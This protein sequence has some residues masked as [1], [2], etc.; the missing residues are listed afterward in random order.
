MPA[1][2]NLDPTRNYLLEQDNY[3]V[4]TWRKSLGSFAEETKALGA[5]LVALG[6]HGVGATEAR[7]KALT[8]AAQHS[9]AAQSGWMKPEVGRIE[10]I[11]LT[12][13][14]GVGR[15]GSYA[16]YQLPKG[17]ALLAGIAGTGGVTGGIAKLGVRKGIKELAKAELRTVAGELAAKKS[18]QAFVANAAKGMLTTPAERLAGQAARQQVGQAMLRGAQVGAG[19]ATLGLETGNLYGD[20]ANDPNVGPEKAVLPSLAGG[21]ASAALEYLPFHLAGKAV[22][23]D[24]LLKGGMLRETIKSTP[25]LSKK[26]RALATRVAKGAASGAVVEG[27]TEGLQ[28]LVQLA[29]EKYAKDDPTWSNV[30]PQNEDEWSRVWNA[31]A[32]GGLVG[33]VAGAGIGGVGKVGQEEVAQPPGEVVPTEAP[34][35]PQPQQQT[36]PQ[37]P[38]PQQP[39]VL[40]Q[41]AVPLQ[42]PVAQTPAPSPLPPAFQFDPNAGLT[43]PAPEGGYQAK[44]LKDYAP[45]LGAG[46]EAGATQVGDTLPVQETPQI[47]WQG[48]DGS[49]ITQSTSPDGKPFWSFNDGSGVEEFSSSESPEVYAYASEKT[50]V[51][52]PEVPN[53]QQEPG[54]SPVYGDVQQ[55]PGPQVGQEE[56][57]PVPAAEGG[58]GIQQE[59]LTSPAEPTTI[60]SIEDGP[61]VGLTPEE[62]STLD[63]LGW[64]KSINIYGAPTFF[65]SQNATIFVQKVGNPKDGYTW[66]ANNAE[67]TLGYY[68]SLQGAI[69]HVQASKKQVVPQPAL[70]ELKQIWQGPGEFSKKAHK[71]ASK[72]PQGAKF[73][74]EAPPPAWE[75]GQPTTKAFFV[76]ESLGYGTVP[77]VFW[78]EYDTVEEAKEAIPGLIDLTEG[79]PTQESPASSKFDAEAEAVAAAY[80]NE[81]DPLTALQME[82]EFNNKY[83][84][85]AFNNWASTNTVAKE[86]EQLPPL[87]HKLTKVG[88]QAGSNNGG[89]YEDELGA[90]YYVKENKTIDQTVS[91]Y[92]ASLLYAA[93]GVPK[94]FTK[95]LDAPE[96][97]LSPIVIASLKASADVGSPMK[98]GFL[99]DAWLANWDVAGESND[100]FLGTK[101]KGIRVDFGGTLRYRAKGK[102]KG[103]SGTKEF[104]DRVRELYTL[105]DPNVNPQAAALF[106]DLT[107]A[108]IIEQAASLGLLKDEDIRK[109]VTTPYSGIVVENAQELADTL[110][111]R[112]QRILNYAAK[113]VGKESVP[114]KHA[115]D[116]WVANWNPNSPKGLEDALK[117]VDPHLDVWA[118]IPKISSQY[119]VLVI[120]PAA[121]KVLLRKPKNNYDGY[122]WTFSKG[123]AEYAEHPVDTAKRETFEE[124][125]Q[126]THIVGLIGKPFYSSTSTGALY[127]V[128][129][130]DGP[131]IGTGAETEATKWVTY[132]E[133]KKLIKEGTNLQE[134]ERDL[135][136]LDYLFGQKKV[137]NVAEY[138]IKQGAFHAKAYFEAGKFAQDLASSEKA[139]ALS[140]KE[141]SQLTDLQ[142]LW[143]KS[144]AQ[145]AYQA[146]DTG[147]IT[148]AEVNAE[149]S[150]MRKNFK[151]WSGGFTF[152][153][154]TS[155]SADTGTTKPIAE[156]AF[157]TGQPMVATVFHGTGGAGIVGDRVTP[158]KTHGTYGVGGSDTTAAGPT[159]W[160]YGRKEHAQGAGSKVYALY[161]KMSNPLVVDHGGHFWTPLTKHIQKAKNN[162]HDGLIV[163]NIEDTS[164]DD[165]QLGTQFVV[166]HGRQ[167]K[168]RYLENFGYSSEPG[169]KIYES[170][171]SG[172]AAPAQSAIDFAAET[173]GLFGQGFTQRAIDSGVLIVNETSPKGAPSGTFNKRTG[174][175][176]INLDRVPQYQTATSVLLHEGR[177]AK[178]GEILG[179]SITEFHNDLQKLAKNGSATARS[180][181]LESTR[182][183]AKSLGIENE[184]GNSA[185]PPAERAGELTRVREEIQRRRPDL[186]LEEDLAYYVQIA[187]SSKTVVEAGFLR[188]LIEAIKTWW[189][190]TG[191]GQALAQ[192]G[193]R[194]EFTP[195]MA[196]ELAKASTRRAVVEAEQMQQARARWTDLLKQMPA[197][198]RQAILESRTDEM[199]VKHE[200]VWSLPITPQL[201]EEALAGQVLYSI[202]PVSSWGDP[203]TWFTSP[204]SGIAENVNEPGLGNKIFHGLVDRFEYVRGRS[205][206]LYRAFDEWKNRQGAMQQEVERQFLDPMVEFVGRYEPSTGD[207]D[208]VRKAKVA[209]GA[210]ENVKISK[211]EMV[212]HQLAARHILEDDVTHKLARRA[213]PE[214]LQQL[215][216]ELPPTYAGTLNDQIALLT[217]GSQSIKELD[218]DDAMGLVEQYLPQASKD[219][220]TRWALMNRRSAGYSIATPGSADATVDLNDGFIN[221]HEIYNQQVKD[222]R[223]FQRIGALSDALAEH[224]LRI[225]QEG[226]LLTESSM[227]SLRNSY[228]HYV[229]LRREKFDYDKEL[230]FLFEKPSKRIGQMI[231][232]EGSETVPSAVHVLQ[233][234][235]AGGFTTA[236]AAARNQMMNKFA[237][238]IYEDKKG[239]GPWFRISEKRENNGAMGFVRNGK[240]LF[241]IPN[242]ENIRAASISAVI[243]GYDAQK[244]AGPMKL[245]RSVNNWIRWSNV[246]ASPI[247]LLSNTPRDY[248]TAVYN[249]QASEAGEYAKE[250]S[251]WKNYKKSFL[252]LKKVILE[253]VRESTDP[254]VRRWIR[255]VEE[256][257]KAGGK[258]SFVEALKTMD[259][260]SWGSFESMVGRREGKLGAVVDWGSKQLKQIENLNIVL[261]NVMRLS[262]FR[263]MKDKVGPARAAEI[264]RNLT[265]NFTRRG[266]H[267]DAMNTWW[268]FYNA[269]VQGNWQVIRNLFLNPNKKAQRRLMKAVGATVL[270]ALL[271]DQLGRAFSDDEDRDGV[272]DWDSRPSWEKERKI[273]LPF[274][275]GG[276]YPSIP[277]PW[278]FNVFWRMGAMLGE[279]KDG[280]IKPQE[281]VMDLVGLTANAMNPIGGGTAAQTLAPTSVDPLIQILE[282]KNFLGNPLDPTGYPGASKRPDAYLAW[283]STPAG[284]RKLAE[285][286]NEVTR[287]NPAESGAIDWR[288]STYKVLADFMMGSLGRTMLDIGEMGLAPFTDEPLFQEATDVPLAKVFLSA[289]S[290]ATAVTLYHDRVAKVLS[291]D[292]LVRMYSEGPER[293]PEKLAQVRQ[294]RA[295][296]LQL[297]PQVKD[298]ERQIKA[299]RKSLR[300]AQARGDSRTEELLRERIVQLQKRFNTS[301]SNRVGN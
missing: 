105:R 117:M 211:V 166:W 155:G 266:A 55:T 205:S 279:A 144:A 70:T 274:K 147:S 257:E 165:D 265:T 134:V 247:F 21:I 5:G 267:I 210:S 234:H 28:E 115:L 8:T 277:A 23:L 284:Y 237:D 11:K 50:G 281:A 32:A 44:T 34:Q 292:K 218:L 129:V 259:G 204:V 26:A 45:D 258:T 223:A 98:D 54:T 99:A 120:D 33:S 18:G 252:A 297:L 69:A 288:P 51:T 118:E 68:T 14:G 275:V 141:W 108:D 175:M 87:N 47:V 143:V 62:Q 224:Q 286:M 227:N 100:N 293:N 84:D 94:P 124:T 219:F 80:A 24:R 30:L 188:R 13:P 112:K 278:V 164:S 158:G 229:P 246:S 38:A 2:L 107:D 214:F 65:P 130:A 66:A 174:V 63:E 187:G 217:E 104:D 82:D 110:I 119:G 122:H 195:Q 221:A 73:I 46:P 196:V 3:K 36:A 296:L 249:L 145:L 15:L 202:P 106:S 199:P 75:D 243:N 301:F 17:L 176:T 263:V 146:G 52:F 163:T 168:T 261:E 276:V 43:E 128:G 116:K 289:P 92:V 228:A 238:I 197:E 253:G 190:Q 139:T 78:G 225:L 127:Y 220:S 256:F 37:Q 287:G 97:F 156:R 102:K 255:D 167:V 95:L 161:V 240:E 59:E 58:Q 271:I 20:L 203:N 74:V 201:R 1:P 162:G 67:D 269:T 154:I 111:D 299:L 90:T 160:L 101:E 93:V 282:N 157:Q 114:A 81:S 291:S 180:A 79:S 103:E 207:F 91:E 71:V 41:E 61:Q 137:S 6:A 270:F 48:P 16:A 169:S 250:I 260:D 57:S 83:G 268:L 226:D 85:G 152:N 181:L 140:K 138:P 177:H 53:A 109:I 25:E 254:E 133:A 29:A 86:T 182:A 191:I 280:V 189:L 251:S 179:D 135:E 49:T 215:R 136:T 113:L 213:A 273:S 40:P 132:E 290:E 39:P 77:A 239:W 236:A 148:E 149:T 241:V 283:D 151:K 10:D 170:S 96:G 264:A 76:E 222:R 216:K 200:T 295:P 172:A 126:H 198:V 142:K 212:G 184:L 42:Q 294:E 121:E 186:L 88:G 60:N 185:L 300:S 248:L 72:L 193:L 7:D 171:E 31:A 231:R 153:Q 208:A 4:P 35:A 285:F 242:S 131:Q 27:A 159:F 19:A 230:A 150:R 232:R 262:A 173:D 56:G 178:M 183:A 244:L 9:E 206:E 235:L 22:G 272:S 123:G 89:W 192:A 64:P 298:V 245:M 233:N 209:A 194:P 12:E 125:G